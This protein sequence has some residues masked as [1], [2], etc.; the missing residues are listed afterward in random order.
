MTQRVK[1]VL[2]C[3]ST[4]SPWTA[5]AIL[6]AVLLL[7]SFAVPLAAQAPTLPGAPFLA[8]IERSEHV[9]TRLEALESLESL[10]LAQEALAQRAAAEASNGDQDLSLIHI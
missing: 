7:S 4:R 10:Q 2:P 8:T 9:L 3:R 6:V 1:A 5:R